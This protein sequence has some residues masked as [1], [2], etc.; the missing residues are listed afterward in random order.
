MELLKI[1]F[2]R[3]NFDI[4]PQEFER[5][6]KIGQEL[7]EIHLMK[8]IPE[9]GSK[10]DCF[11]PDFDKIVVQKVRYDEKEQRVYLNEKSY[12]EKVHPEVWNYKIGGYQVLDKYLKSRKDRVLSHLEIGH[13]RDVVRVIEWTIE[14]VEQI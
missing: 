7:I 13:I 4:S 12:F 3:V 6:A 2:P 9:T 10:V 14:V 11:A 1:D 5:L 8:K